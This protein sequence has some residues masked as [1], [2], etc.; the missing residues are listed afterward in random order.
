M[1]TRKKPDGRRNNGRPLGSGILTNEERFWRKVERGGPDSCWMWRAATVNGYG[2]FGLRS[3]DGIQ[4]MRGAHRVS[5][6]W[7]NGRLTTQGEVVRHLCGVRGCVNPAHLAVGGATENYADFAATQPP[8]RKV[9]HA[10]MKARAA[11]LGVTLTEVWRRAAVAYL[12][13]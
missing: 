1:T 5:W 4:R 9:I 3:P 12:A 7:A 8:H 11:S 6:E 10:E 13:R 2:A